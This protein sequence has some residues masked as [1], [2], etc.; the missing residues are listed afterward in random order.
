MLHSLN[1]FPSS[2][3]NLFKCEREKGPIIF[4]DKK[5]EE[6]EECCKSFPQGNNGKDHVN[7]KR[8]EKSTQLL[9]R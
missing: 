2:E 5:E 6:E 9:L 3:S 7:D 8:K 4:R 1:I